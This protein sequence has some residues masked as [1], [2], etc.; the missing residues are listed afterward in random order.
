MA[1]AAL[2]V[3]VV[4]L[5][6][7]RL[8]RTHQVR[9]GVRRAQLAGLARL[10]A[11]SALQELVAEL[12]RGL[13]R[14]EAPV[15]AF[16]R[17]RLVG[18]WEELD[19]APLLPR[20]EIE[21]QPSWGRLGEE[22]A[23]GRVFGEI[24]GYSARVHG[25]APVP[26]PAGTEE[27]VAVV[28]LGVDVR[29]HDAF[30]ALTRHLEESYELRAT[31]VG[32]PRPFDQ[33]G[34]FGGE[35]AAFTDRARVAAGRRDLLARAGRVRAELAAR[36]TAGW[37]AHLQS[38]F[39]RIVEGMPEA[40]VLE[41]RVPRLP[42]TPAALS[43]FDHVADVPLTSLD[44]AASLE[45]DLARIGELERAYRAAAGDAQAATDAA[46][47]LAGELSNAADRV[48]Q[49][50]RVSRVVPHEG[51]FQRDFAP[52]LGRL[53]GAYWRARA[54][55]AGTPADADLAG[56][57]AG[58]HRLE[59]VVDMTAAP[60]QLRLAGRLKGRV[61]V[62]V[63]PR[64][65]RLETAAAGGEP[66]DRLVVVSLGGD[67]EVAGDCA[68]AIL[69]LGGEDGEPGRLEVPGGARL[70]GAVLAPHASEGGPLPLRGTLVPDKALL[71]PWPPAATVHQAGAGSYVLALDP[72]PL[73]GAG[74]AR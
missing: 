21:W 73:W 7:L 67:V 6:T 30:G 17:E 12:A 20:P 34:I 53:D 26:D 56:W 61:A 38:Y 16:L 45:G 63:G 74:E 22:S 37:P 48:W 5:G 43:G 24:L 13:N 68:A 66:G 39:A 54:H 32:P 57:L 59:G 23:R 27:F 19:L 64:G 50:Q 3:L 40:D 42:A 47:A 60:A 41:E 36:D 65:A 55:L 29:V 18:E 62:L 72:R 11:R 35:L 8:T 25:A 15:F 70:R 71:G 31:L 44:L 51:E 9:F 49:Y 33:L 46:Y 69:M 14:P 4:S 52:F 2:G 1:I 28:T 58:A 10:Q